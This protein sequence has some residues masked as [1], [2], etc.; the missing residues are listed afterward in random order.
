M[1]NCTCY[2]CDCMEEYD[3]VMKGEQSCEGCLIEVGLVVLLGVLMAL[4]P[5]F[6]FAVSIFLT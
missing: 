6:I 2:N 5:P 4:L 1:K 3:V